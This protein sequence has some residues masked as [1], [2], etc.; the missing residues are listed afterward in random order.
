M[1]TTAA[2]PEYPNR[3]GART[4]GRDL[5]AEWKAKDGRRTFV[6][7][8]AGFAAV[9]FNSDA[10]VFGLFEPSHMQYEADR[11]RDGKGEPSLADMTK[12]AITRL[13]R[14]ADGYVLMVEAGRIDHAHHAGNAARAL[15]DTAA[16]DEAIGAAL[17][18][19]DASETLIIVTADHSHTFVIQGYPGRNNNILDVMRYPGESEPGRGLD[20]KPFTTLA[21]TN[22][23]GSICERKDGAWVCEREDL[24]NVDTKALD[25]LQ[26]STIPL[27]SETHGGE[28]VALFASGP[29]ANLFSG[30]I[31]QHEIFHVMAKSLGLV[32]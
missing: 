2:D 30:T 4:D 32:R 20:G 16:F 23:P 22:G 12:A 10:Q 29:A 21:Y 8:T 19:T 5:V 6:S 15:A 7:D 9:N 18:M 28:D 25:Y 13:S 14:D 3:T 17:T 1:P 31:E 11:A 27:S 26:Q 24:N